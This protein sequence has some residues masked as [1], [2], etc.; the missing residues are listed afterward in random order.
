MFVDIFAK[1][2]DDAGRRELDFFLNEADI[3]RY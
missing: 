2:G 3:D 1:V